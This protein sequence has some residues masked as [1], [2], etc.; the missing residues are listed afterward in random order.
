MQYRELFSLTI[1]HDYY[2]D[3]KCPDFTLSPTP[4]CER[5]LRNY[6][7]LL[8]SFPY[9]I[10]VLA[11][12][13]QQESKNN[14]GETIIEE[15]LFLDIPAG[16]RFDF[17]LRLNNPQFH[18]ITSLEQTYSG[19][20]LANPVFSNESFTGPGALIPKELEATRTEHLEVPGSLPVG[21]PEF[22]TLLQEN[23]AQE[24]ADL[25]L[26]L[27]SERSLQKIAADWTA[28][29]NESD[30]ED[31]GFS[32][33]KIGADDDPLPLL[34][35]FET[36]ARPFE[37]RQE[38]DNGGILISYHGAGKAPEVRVAEL[39][40]ANH[41][42]YP[43]D[44][45]ASFDVLPGQ[46]KLSV[47]IKKA[48]QAGIEHAFWSDVLE[49]WKN[50]SGRYGFRLTLLGPAKSKWVNDTG[51]FKK[52]LIQDHPQIILPAGKDNGIRISYT[53]SNK[54]P[55]V[56]VLE[57][58]NGADTLFKVVDESSQ[59]TLQGPAGI[60][61]K[62]YLKPANAV[63]FTFSGQP[64][65]PFQL[66]YPVRPSLP[67]GVFGKVEIH[68]KPGFANFTSAA[69]DKS[70]FIDFAPAASYWAY[71]IVSEFELRDG[72]VSLVAD[73]NKIFHSPGEGKNGLVEVSFE[74]VPIDSG[75]L[76]WSNFK[77][78][79][80]I[81]KAQLPPADLEQIW[82]QLKE[83]EAKLKQEGKPD[84]IRFLFISHDKIPCRERYAGFL[85]LEVD[86]ANRDINMET[87]GIQPYKVKS[88]A[89]PMA[90]NN[91]IKLVRLAFLEV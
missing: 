21:A 9:G 25:L 66:T 56:K 68:H 61:I 72:E 7:L 43:G 2:L 52:L 24:T 16:A 13:R 82:Q 62:E 19:K 75:A 55:R 10:Q 54:R 5:R 18:A 90:R 23:P 41:P 81:K 48:N 36:L 15:A 38:N 87:K 83:I 6:R 34:P 20:L 79:S 76:G 53:G 77:N 74:A 32:I 57:N 39:E 8:K 91:Q 80:N 49:E 33:E 85:S 40:N 22:V 88:M 65:Q 45:A 78:N 64:G 3:R 69:A 1:R 71:Y 4:E 30:T 35:Y 17:W 42:F 12:V 51:G 28:W 37:F 29:L 11:P 63:K 60:G 67:W 50:F 46:L 26:F 59:F 44:K 14:A 58:G 47:F 89:L 31:K 73:N 84:N 27:G 86:N 70:L